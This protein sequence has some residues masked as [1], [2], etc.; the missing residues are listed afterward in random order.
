M[1]LYT[2]E[3]LGECK[4]T[5]KWARLGPGI[6]PIGSEK[7]FCSLIR[8]PIS[9]RFIE[10]LDYVLRIAN[11]KD[12]LSAFKK[13]REED[14]YKDYQERCRQFSPL[15]APKPAPPPAPPPELG[16]P[17]RPPISPRTYVCLE[18]CRR[19]G[20]RCPGGR[21]SAECQRGFRECMRNCEGVLA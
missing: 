19:E 14:C 8:D 7:E 17:P 12:R 16:P 15:P 5:S 11:P 9:G 6:D 21:L 1:Y 2:Q 4:S 18:K 20:Q 3:G 10:W 13:F